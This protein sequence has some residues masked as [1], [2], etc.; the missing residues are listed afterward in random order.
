MKLLF[1][2]LFSALI[3]TYAFSQTSVDVVT[4]PGYAND[5]YYSFTGDT[6]KTA[7]RS[8]WDIAFITSQ[9]SVSALANNGAGVMVYTWPGGTIE[10][11]ETVDTTGIVWTPIYNS[12][13][14][15]EEGAFNAHATE[16]PDY[17]WG[18]YNMANHN[19]YG[20][21]IFIVKCPV[22]NSMIVKKFAIVLKNASQNVWTFK[23]ADLNGENE[24]TV[25]LEGNNYNNVSYIHYSLVNDS[26][27]EQ[28]PAEDWQLLFTKYYDYNIPY[29][30]TGVLANSGVQ[31]QQ[32]NGVSQAD[33]VD[34]NSGVFN[35]TISEI[36]SDW[37][38]FSMATFQYVVAEDVVYFVQFKEANDTENQIWKIYFTGFSGSSTGTYSF[39]K[40]D[41]LSTGI[42][43]NVSGKSLIAYPNPAK[44]E[45]NIIHD[46]DGAVEITVYNISGQLVLKQEATE[47]AG[48]N[49][50]TLNISTLPSGIYNAKLSSGNVSKS[51]KFIK[52]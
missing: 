23:Y 37:K 28:E 46:F 49:K 13:E 43:D 36:G 10:D 2:F 29:Y 44:G 25:T 33:F 18:I 9:M 19:I 22:G 20:D 8:N 11:W 32:V 26:I 6:L 7:P 14:D 38:S 21:S 40:Q 24:K 41:M 48:L 45:L 12:I 16:H 34:Y 35:D 4:G 51:V 50:Q 5:V 1:T 52:E 39:V 17:G 27:V 30:V 47:D 3:F 42:K 31:I 15:W